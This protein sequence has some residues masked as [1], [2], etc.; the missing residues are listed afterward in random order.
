MVISERDITPRDKIL[1]HCIIHLLNSGNWID[2]M[3]ADFVGTQ[4]SVVNLLDLS[5]VCLLVS[6]WFY[7]YKDF[8]H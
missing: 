6:F 4:Y 1:D 3:G 2:A 5:L 7:F 8:K